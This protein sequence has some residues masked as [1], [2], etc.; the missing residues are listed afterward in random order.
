MSFFY[1]VKNDMYIILYNLY[2][3]SSRRSTGGDTLSVA[4]SIRALSVSR[5]ASLS[6]L[7]VA[8]GMALSGEKASSGILLAAFGLGRHFI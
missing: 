8:L 2:L 3:V 5:L 7:H 1:F 4:L 6:T